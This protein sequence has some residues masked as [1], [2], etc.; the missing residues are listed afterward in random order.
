MT[1]LQSA[2]SSLLS[3]VLSEEEGEVAAAMDP[4]V[5]DL[6]RS[7]GD[8]Y[9]DV[10]DMSFVLPTSQSSSTTGTMSGSASCSG[11]TDG[12]WAERK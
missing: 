8:M 5:W 4:E 7:F 9:T 10:T 6:S 3:S 1:A 12:G 2:S 11:D